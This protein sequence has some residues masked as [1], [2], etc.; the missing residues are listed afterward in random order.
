MQ[1]TGLDQ[2]VDVA[3]RFE[4]RVQLQRRIRPQKAL[5]ELPL[6]MLP[7]P[8]ILDRQERPR[9]IAVVADKLVA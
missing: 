7:N 9:V 1:D 2:I 4:R 8:V 5:V 3:P 6:D